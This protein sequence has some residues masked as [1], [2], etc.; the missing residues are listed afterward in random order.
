MDNTVDR[1]PSLVRDA[2]DKL[3]TFIVTVPVKSITV[4]I[5]ATT[6]KRAAEAVLDQLNAG[7]LD[8]DEPAFDF[9]HDASC[10]AVQE[11]TT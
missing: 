9:T 10:C 11:V 3:R 8:D 7:H 6:P 5:D 1:A 4:A 2:I